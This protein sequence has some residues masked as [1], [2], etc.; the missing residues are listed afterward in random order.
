MTMI[1]PWNR[2]VLLAGVIA[3]FSAGLTPAH[4]FGQ[5]A[6][7]SITGRVTDASGAAIPN[8]TVTLKNT[9]TS[10]SQTASTDEQGRYALQ[11]L[12]IGTYNLTL[13][14]TGFQNVARTGL[15]VTVGAAAVLDFQMTVGQASETVS[16]NA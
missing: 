16:V 3:L 12:P 6:T 5:A 10:A 13:S 1:S 11:D 7:S 8:A 9:A 2:G 15:I 4:L 14:K